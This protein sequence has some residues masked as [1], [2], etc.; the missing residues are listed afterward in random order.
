MA[1]SVATPAFKPYRANHTP[2]PVEDLA[3]LGARA[4]GLPGG[5][6]RHGLVPVYACL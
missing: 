5:G 3:L 6:R 1:W 4:R 2:R